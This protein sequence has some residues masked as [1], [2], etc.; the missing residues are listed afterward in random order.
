MTPDNWKRLPLGVLQSLN[1]ASAL[2]SQLLDFALMLF[3]LIVL[4]DF[5]SFFRF[6]RKLET[7]SIRGF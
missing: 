6:L 7:L 5:V 4:F 3:K 2:L 1:G